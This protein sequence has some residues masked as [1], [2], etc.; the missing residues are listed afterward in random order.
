MA[1]YT[2]SELNNPIRSLD[3][4]WEG[5][6]HQEVESFV[7]GVLR[8]LTGDVAVALNIGIVGDDTKI[9]LVDASTATFQYTVDY[10]VDGAPS[11]NYAVN[12][13]IGNRVIQSGY[14]P[15]VGPNTPITSPE[16]INYLKSLG[17]TIIVTIEVYDEAS[18]ITRSRIVTFNKRQANLVSNNTL[19]TVWTTSAQ[20]RLSYTKTISYGSLD[21]SN[22]GEAKV[23]SVFSDSSGY[24]ETVQT[25]FA[26]A[27]NQV[28][29]PVPT[30]LANGPCSV[31]SYIML[32][33]PQ[34]TT[35]NVVTDSIIIVHDGTD[36]IAA[37][38][39]DTIYLT[40]GDVVGASV[41]NY[42][43]VRY[44]IYI[45]GGSPS[46]RW[47]VVLQKK[48]NNT[49]VDQAKKYATNN[50][51]Q[52]WNY[53]VTDAT[54]ELR[55]LIPN[56]SPDGSIYYDTGGNISTRTWKT[57]TINATPSDI[58]W[59]SATEGLVFALSALN[60][61]NGDY[62]IGNWSDNGYSAIFQDMQWDGSGSGWTEITY[63]DYE[64]N[65]LTSNALRLVGKSR[66]TIGD[67]FPFYKS[68]AFASGIN[69]GG[70]LD[71]GGTFKISFLVDNVSNA[72]ENVISCWDDTLGFYVTGDGFYLN[73]GNELIDNP[74]MNQAISQVNTR[75]F[76]SGVKI[77]LTIVVPSYY[78]ISGNITNKEVCYYINGEIAGYTRLDAAINTLSQSTRTPVTFGG[79]GAM[80]YLFDVAYYNRP[81]SALEVF[82][83]YT[84]KLDS[85]AQINGIFEKNNFYAE[86]DNKAVVTINQAIEYGKY[87]AEQGKTNFAVW[88]STN[89]CNQED[90]GLQPG[91]KNSTK[92]QTTR[93]EK[94][95]YFRFTTDANG[96]GI[97]DTDLSFFVDSELVN[98]KGTMR[99]ALRFRRQGTSTVDATKGNIRID[100]QA[101]DKVKLYRFISE[102]AG[103]S[104]EEESIL[105]KKARIWQIPDASAL[106][107]YLLTLKKNPNDS[108]QA[109]NLPTAKWYEDCARYLAAQN[110]EMYGKC[111]TKPQR[112]ELES[113]I[114]AR[115][116]LSLSEAVSLVKTRQ[117]VDGIPTIGFR[118]DYDYA[119]DEATKFNPL[120][121]A[122]TSFGGQFDAITDKTN[123]DV[124][125]FGLRNT[126]DADGHITQT[127]L[128]NTPEG[129]QDFSI[130]WRNNGS[131]VCCFQTQNLAGSG[132][133][134]DIGPNEKYGSGYLE[135]RYPT[136]SPYVDGEDMP[137]YPWQDN[138]I[139]GHTTIGL[140]SNGPIQRLFDLVATCSPLKGDVEYSA[141][142]RGKSYWNG[143]EVVDQQGRIPLRNN[144]DGIISWLDDN[145]ANRKTIFKTEFPK[146]VNLYQFLLN[147]LLI[148]AG[149]MVDQDVKNQFFTHYTGDD[150]EYGHKL[151]C[152]LGY[153][154]DSS[155]GMDNDNNF[156]FEYTVRYED[157][158]YDGNGSKSNLS[159]LWKLVYDCYRSEITTMAGVLYGAN[160]LNY[161]GVSRY[162]FENEIDMFNSIIY[163]NN[164]EY[165]YMS[166][167]AS[168]WSKVHGSAKEHNEWFV[169][170]RMYFIGGEYLSAGSDLT[171]DLAI[172]D[173][174]YVASSE[175]F[176]NNPF[177]A[178][179]REQGSHGLYYQLG[180][181]AY[182][183]SYSAMRI[184]SAN[185]GPKATMEVSTEY[186]PTTGLPTGN[187]TYSTGYI[188]W[189]TH[190][191]TASDFHLYIT[192][193]KD[194]KT[195]EGLPYIFINSISNWGKLVNI[196]SLE[197]GSTES[198][199]VQGE[200]YYYENPYLTSLNT[201][202]V[203]FGSC[204]TLNLAGL[205][206]IRGVL[207]LASFPILETF[208]GIRMPNVTSI[209]HPAG[210]SLKS[211]SY[212]ANLISWIINNKPNLNSITFEG[213]NS[214]TT[215]SVTN[216][217]N[218]A[219]KK[220]IELLNALTD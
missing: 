139:Y 92:D 75:R 177:F 27:I 59:A 93:G 171:G 39:E 81:L 191:E 122:V 117:C 154:F 15:G 50:N 173:P 126:Q 141:T 69:G 70:I 26:Q 135:Y 180:M 174:R 21:Q 111:L 74:N 87:L 160:L 147:A 29:V 114:E 77:D 194:I 148:D 109:R 216:S 192:G 107:C 52:T 13:K 80:L 66:M 47:P 209:S 102:A 68:T 205:S 91:D 83:T 204:K 157:G 60:K 2:D 145:E 188:G 31:S 108:T 136:D 158:L 57:V 56:L 121:D 67:F 110:Y 71:T 201:G 172:F 36:G 119:N 65:T 138:S 128:S 165:S 140:E 17:N 64:G 85:S 54:T 200:T 162:M 18:G 161:S 164:S 78:D 86:I 99:S 151:L 16:L 198:M 175:S 129:D 116:S 49:Y 202:G 20:T 167:R 63:N 146:C 30:T 210:S 43:S 97:I 182:R 195:I 79:D 196:E 34:N 73:I 181:T 220:A 5:H 169:E 24:T 211:V 42:A 58:G 183:R 187:M 53:L 197:L 218:V 94:F 143:E 51:V 48:I 115:P 179:R 105:S 215:I 189:K 186:D 113:I 214:L 7:S 28:R 62:D 159:M 124:F 23:I 219:A 166:D 3:E 155:W 12:I 176:Y 163:N 6:T 82:H 89:L 33:D 100:V 120:N 207:S 32:G 212:P 9:F 45:V 208:V 76:Q 203:L 217:S 137:T 44:N 88:L 19:G 95:Y 46:L 131:D 118:I 130:E 112:V 96:R 199:E 106:P 101:A 149:L 41:N 127:K 8:E 123:M 90:T 35:G 150:D 152:L 14:R 84:M 38:E 25:P 4:A 213:Y 170:G 178:R 72:H 184:G 10:S 190:T 168:D 132:T 104:T 185:L 125:G 22:I 142:L 61:S 133:Q 134:I 55:V 193:C 11:T 103:F 153:D 144:N 40:V 1:V 206:G 156:R 37:P 98:I